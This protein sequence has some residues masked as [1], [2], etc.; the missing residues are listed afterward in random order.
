MKMFFTYFI[1]I[2]LLCLCILEKESSDRAIESENDIELPAIS[3]EMTAN[4]IFLIPSGFRAGNDLIKNE[5]IN[6]NDFQQLI[7]TDSLHF[8]FGTEKAESKIF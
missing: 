5:E 8:Y 1:A 7:S 3:S 4:K 2:L 6:K